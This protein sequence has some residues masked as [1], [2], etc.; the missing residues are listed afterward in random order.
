MDELSASEVPHHSRVLDC[1]LGLGLEHR[2]T[3]NPLRHIQTLPFA[4]KIN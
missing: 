1:G 4:L 3:E 2:H